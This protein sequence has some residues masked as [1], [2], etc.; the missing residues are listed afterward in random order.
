[1][2]RRVGTIPI[3]DD[4]SERPEHRD[5]KLEPDASV[6][7]PES[8]RNQKVG[9]DGFTD[10]VL[11]DGIGSG[12]E[13]H[14]NALY[15]RYF[16]RIYNF[17]YGRIRNHS[18]AEEI[19]QETFTVVFSSMGNYRG[20]S[21]LLSWIYGIAKNTANSTLR[22]AK[23]H[24]RQLQEVRPEQLRPNPSLGTCSPEEKL[25]IQRYLGSVEDQLEQLG[26]WQAE[27]FE[28]RHLRNMSIGEIS[29]QTQRSSDSVR[30]SLYRVKRLLLE[31]ARFD[32]PHA[33]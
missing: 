16:Q 20:R 1:L 3:Q 6:G 5:R 24:T 15:R 19:V 4:G 26:E 10:Q 12:S 14:F 17:V 30:S 28:M 32:S 7:R 21:S 11:I 33:A 31:T 18:D 29:E 8:G 27:I 25:A 23:N 9:A 22:Q 2:P 13:L